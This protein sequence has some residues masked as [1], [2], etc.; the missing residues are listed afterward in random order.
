MKDLIKGFFHLSKIFIHLKYNVLCY[1]EARTETWQ[2]VG[3]QL[4]LALTVIWIFKQISEDRLFC[5]TLS[6]FSLYIVFDFFVLFRSTSHRLTGRQRLLLLLLLFRFSKSSPW[7]SPFSVLPLCSRMLWC[8]LRQVFVFAFLLC[9]SSLF[10]RAL[11]LSL[12]SLCS[13]LSA[14]ALVFVASK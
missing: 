9:A 6:S 4:P 1:C 13:C 8:S 5:V 14:F 11:V 7:F 12:S 10:S 3:H 2:R